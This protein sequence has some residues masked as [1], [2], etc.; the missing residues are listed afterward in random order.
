MGERNCLTHMVESHSTAGIQCLCGGAF[1][2]V[3]LG[4][5]LELPIT[6]DAELFVS[7][8]ATS[9]FNLFCCKLTK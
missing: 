3:Y 6:M 9:I 2:V 5:R 8:E 7:E 1:I 4:V